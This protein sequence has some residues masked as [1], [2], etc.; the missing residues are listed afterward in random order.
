MTYYNC[1][2]SKNTQILF[3]ISIN[4]KEV[5]LFFKQKQIKFILDDI[6]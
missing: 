6:R 2:L 3:I 1:V 4:I 5:Q